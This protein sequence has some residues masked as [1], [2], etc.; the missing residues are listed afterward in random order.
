MDE[1]DALA[2]PGFDLPA[3]ALA[4]IPQEDSQAAPLASLA[5][6]GLDSLG[7]APAPAAAAGGSSSPTLKAAGLEGLVFE[8][9]AP[10][11]HTGACAQLQRL[12]CMPTLHSGAR[13]PGQEGSRVSWEPV[14]SSSSARLQVSS[15]ELQ[16][17]GC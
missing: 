9:Q 6:A 14:P 7:T 2:V 17:F 11:A 1:L 12:H 5:G 15:R 4:K 10:D 8:P 3:E 13:P 16:A